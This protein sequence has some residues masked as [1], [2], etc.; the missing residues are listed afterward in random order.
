ML[1]SHAR[2][3]A[4]LEIMA[5]RRRMMQSLL[6]KST[7]APHVSLHAPHSVRFW[8]AFITGYTS[9]TWKEDSEEREREGE[10]E[11]ASSEESGRARRLRFPRSARFHRRRRGGIV[12]VLAVK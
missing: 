5:Y 8:V 12:V 10:G 6:H 11:R 7:T 9:C 1:S 2:G 3:R 4:S